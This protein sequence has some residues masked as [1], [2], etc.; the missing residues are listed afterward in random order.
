MSDLNKR[1]VDVIEKSLFAVCLDDY[2]TELD[3][4]KSHHNYFHGFTAH[5]RWFDKSF[6]FILLNDG[7]AG[8]NGEVCYPN[9]CLSAKMW[10]TV[11]DDRKSILLPM[12]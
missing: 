11:T 2:S 1:S 7:R 3:V 5:N 12:R 4:D 6:N 8:C 10:P 9:E